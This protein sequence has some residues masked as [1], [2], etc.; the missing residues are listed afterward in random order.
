MSI[1]AT[2]TLDEDVIERVK[3][4]SRTRGE[5]FRNTLND[6]LRTALLNVAAVP[7]RRGFEIRP[8]HMGFGA[9]LNHDNVES[10]IDFG[11]GDRHR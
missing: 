3:H 9:G 8:L 10:L 2:V 4:V 5:S 7:T 11:E 6:L 1:R